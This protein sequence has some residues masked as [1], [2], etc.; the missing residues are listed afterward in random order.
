[1]IVIVVVAIVRQEVSSRH[2]KVGDVGGPRHQRVQTQRR[3]AR[4][5]FRYYMQLLHQ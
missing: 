4:D 5:G 3:G 1:M 2:R